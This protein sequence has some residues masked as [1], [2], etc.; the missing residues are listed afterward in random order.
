MKK[1]D[2]NQEYNPLMINVFRSIHTVIALI[3]IAAVVIIYHSSLTETY[4]LLLYLASA[5]LL[6]EAV[7]VVAN[8]GDCPLSYMQRKYGDNKAFFELFLP[9]RIAKQMFRFNVVVIAIAYFLLLLSL[10]T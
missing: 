1:T 10:L 3:M 9:K 8:K 4:G 5:A 2:T 6:L 7:A